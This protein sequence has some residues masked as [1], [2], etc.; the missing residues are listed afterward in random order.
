LRKV[1]KEYEAENSREN[2]IMT[3]YLTVYNEDLLCFSRS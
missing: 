1:N 3:Y 2:S